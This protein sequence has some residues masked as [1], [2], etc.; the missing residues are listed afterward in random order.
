LSFAAVAEAGMITITWDRNTESNLAGYIVSYGLA[1][2][3][4]DATVDVGLNTTW[5][6]TP[7][8]NQ[9]YY[10]RVQAYNTDGAKSPYSNEASGS[11]GVISTPSPGPTPAPNPGGS[12]PKMSV[13]I[14]AQGST[15][16]AGFAVAGWAADLGAASGPGVDAIHVWAYPV[17]GAAPF[18]VGAGAI[19][20]TRGDVAAAFGKPGMA[21]SGFS[22]TISDIAPGTYDLAVFARS[23]IAGTF[24]NAQV[25]RVNVQSRATRPMMV[26][27]VPSTG[28]TVSGK[29]QVAGWAVDF[30]SP[31]GPGVDTVHVWAYPTSGAAPIFMGAATMN[32]SR[33]D[34]AGAFGAQFKNSGYQLLATAPPGSYNIVVFS[35]SAVANT[36]NNTM[37]VPLTVR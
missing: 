37:M 1:S 29:F 7:N 33:P 35:H 13:D 30:A 34:V 31:S 5:T 27:D 22:L 21:T 32:V 15:V 2:G 26:V 25:V 10:F 20:G 36:F 12:V 18:F 4:V 19:G 28:T 9:T 24:N 8:S 6:L 16:Q 3:R 23:T 17:T 11:S 14:P